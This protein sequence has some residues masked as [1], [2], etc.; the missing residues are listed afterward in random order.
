MSDDRVLAALDRL[1]GGLA[2]LEAGQAKLEAGQAKL[3]A[4]QA[5]LEASV[6]NLEYELTRFRVDAMTRFETLEDRLTAFR[7]DIVVNMAR[8]DLAAD[9]ASHNRKE[10]GQLWRMIQRLQNRVDHLESKP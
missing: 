3:E 5:K 9:L 10:L 4:G 2:K 6:G 7:E 1:E 8:A